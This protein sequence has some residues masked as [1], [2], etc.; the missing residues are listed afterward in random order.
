MKAKII[1]TGAIGEVTKV[2]AYFDCQ[3]PVYFIQIGSDLNTFFP[4][5]IELLN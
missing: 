2:G 5:E 3:K 1:S 4:E